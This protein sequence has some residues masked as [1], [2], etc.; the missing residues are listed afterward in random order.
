MLDLQQKQTTYNNSQLSFKNTK[1][2]IVGTWAYR[3]NLIIV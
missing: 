2:N 3:L 1:A